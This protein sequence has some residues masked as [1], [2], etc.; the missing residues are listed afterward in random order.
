MFEPI[1]AAHFDSTNSARRCVMSG[2]WQY[3]SRAI[4]RRAAARKSGEAGF[5]IYYYRCP[6]DDCRWWHL[7]KQPTYVGRDTDPARRSRR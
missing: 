6:H 7:T 5:A 2:K 3:R 4:A 1:T